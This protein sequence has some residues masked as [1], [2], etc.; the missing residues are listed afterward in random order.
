MSFSRFCA[1]LLS[2]ALMLSAAPCARAAQEAHSEPKIQ[3]GIVLFDGVQIIDFSAPYEVFG[4]AGFGVT[5]LSVDGK[6]VTTAMGLKVTPDLAFAAAPAFDVLLVPGG[7]VGDARKDARILEFVRA[8]SKGA[9][10]VLSV[11]TGAAIVAASGVLDGLKATTFKPYLDKF[12]KDFPKVQV[13]R[14]V[15]W[16]DN[17]TVI[18]AAGLASGIDGALH[19]VA[20][21]RG[22]EV[23][24]STAVHLEY[25]WKPEGGF[26]RSLLAD[27]YVP[28]FDGVR[29]P[30][31]A[32]FEDRYAYGDRD[33]WRARFLVRTAAK[34]KELLAVIAARMGQAPEWKKD[35]AG[36]VWHAQQEG[37]SLRLA[38]TTD[39]DGADGKGYLLDVALD[40]Q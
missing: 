31:D 21:L 2:A 17:G 8:R 19:V 10:A 22:I 18:T 33:H 26:V 1:A 28:N 24:R 25:D 3:V 9:K 12:A 35:A 40:A 37:R 20:R 11:C 30:A 23:A 34:P 14:D 4:A 6:P 36:A 29:W 7:D 15:R 16:V 27:R 32:K 38:F 5:T 13:I 39:G